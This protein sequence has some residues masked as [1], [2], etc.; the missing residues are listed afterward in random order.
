M[1]A[2]KQLERLLMHGEIH[3]A[4]CFACDT[5]GLRG[6]S[7][8]QY[9]CNKCKECLPL[10]AFS[11]ETRK[12]HGVRAWRCEECQRPTCMACGSKPVKALNFDYG[13]PAQYLCR[14]CLYPPCS[15]GCGKPRPTK[16]Q[17]RREFNVHNLPLWYCAACRQ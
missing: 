1:Y 11:V 14:S 12:G 17:G 3:K 6:R 4:I 9:T 8:K 5:T 10:E 16:Y 15:G 7:G 13:D 2:A